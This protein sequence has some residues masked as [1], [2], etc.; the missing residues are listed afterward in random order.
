M[1]DNQQASSGVSNTICAKGLRSIA[2]RAAVTGALYS[3][4]FAQITIGPP[5]RIDNGRGTQPC[6]ETT[7]SASPANPLEII[8]G[9]N[10]YVAGGVRA[11]FGLSLDGGASWSDFELR[12]PAPFQSSVEG[13]PMS[14]YDARTGTLWAGAMAFS[15][16]GGMYVARKDPG[17]ATFEPAVM[18]H[19]ANN[20]DK[21]WMAAG[22]GPGDPN[23]TRV[24]CAYN[25]GVVRSADMGD[26]WSFP[27]ALGPGIGFLPRVGASGNVYVA[28]WDF[29]FQI[30]MHRSLDG[31]QTFGPPIKIADRMDV[32][33][34]DGTRTPGNFRSPS[35]VGF[36][37]SPV[38]ESLYV[39][40]PDT[41]SIESNGS[42]V[43]V[44]FSQSTDAG[45]TWSVPVVINDDAVSPPGDQFFPW[46][47]CDEDGGLHCLFFDTRGVVQN[48]SDSVGFIDSY[49]SYSTDAG[50]N[51]T[52]H[53]LTTTPANS[54]T[55]FTGG[56]FMGDYLGMSVAGHRVIPTY[57]DTPGGDSDVY[58]RVITVGPATEFCM[59]IDCPCGNDDGS[60]GCG[61]LGFDGQVGTGARLS[62]TGSA[63]V[64]L[65]DLALAVDGV[66]AGQN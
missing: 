54:G 8:T 12:P 61:N 38:D 10:Q 7:A 58:T 22:P 59:G 15:A 27:V 30:N 36:A 18:A 65:G 14:A 13:D 16:N 41:T 53:K 57:L 20:V 48:D 40:Y 43:D 17:S 35:L 34:I 5:I 64:I 23:S 11:G 26:T 39:V 47:E 1:V 24:Y 28:S 21:G 9:W 3:A 52:E 46:I 4:T 66:N 63:N 2:L 60:A 55:A 56:V 25:F 51:W 31:G 49:Y 37:V 6:N 42:N 19:T 44:Y 33:G 29:S 50:A 32:W 62:A 45:L